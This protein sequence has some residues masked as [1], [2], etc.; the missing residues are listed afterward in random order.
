MSSISERL[1]P[2]SESRDVAEA[3]LDAVEAD[4]PEEVIVKLHEVMPG[5]ACLDRLPPAA[6]ESNDKTKSGEK[7]GTDE[8]HKRAVA[9]RLEG[10]M[11]QAGGTERR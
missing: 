2:L 9:W 8:R 7:G 3:H 1:P 5:A 4:V 6:G 10:L 11:V